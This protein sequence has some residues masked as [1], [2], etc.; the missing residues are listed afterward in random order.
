MRPALL[1]A[2]V[3]AN[4]S[5]QADLAAMNQA[6]SSADAKLGTPPSAGPSIAAVAGLQ[7]A[8][9]MSHDTTV[10]QGAHADLLAV[11]GVARRG[12]GR[13]SQGDST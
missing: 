7:P 3:G 11:R 5:A 6:L 2:R 10:L 9:D 4:A 12:P 1:A 13:R 8:A